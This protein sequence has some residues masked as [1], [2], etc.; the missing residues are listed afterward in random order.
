MKR[1]A[2]PLRYD[3]DAYD[4]YLS[5]KP[6][7]LLILALLFLCR[8]YLIPIM[9][10]ATSLG[11]SRTEQFGALVYGGNPL[12]SL[13]AGIPALF[14][15]YALRRRTPQSDRFAMWAWQHGRMLLSGSALAQL[16]PSV[17]ALASDSFAFGGGTEGAAALFS[18]FLAAFLLLYVNVS[19][20][21]RD[22]FAD[23]PAQIA[24]ANQPS[25]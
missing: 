2:N 6:P 17:R 3:L 14:V 9:M 23:F 19:S 18:I 11:G 16:V 12:V 21:V 25:P 22:V 13:I 10:L 24:E 1:I 15:L 4:Q 20:R 5:L 7:G 8:S